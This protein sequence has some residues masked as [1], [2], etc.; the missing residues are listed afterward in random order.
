M[1]IKQHLLLEHNTMETSTNHPPTGS[2]LPDIRLADSPTMPPRR[3][4]P[5]SS[6]SKMPA[7]LVF[8]GDACLPA[9][10]VLAQAGLD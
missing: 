6:M 4:L 8:L 1:Q 9:V 2:C 3:C 10:L 7:C 5:A